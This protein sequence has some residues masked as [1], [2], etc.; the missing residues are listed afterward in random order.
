MIAHKSSCAFAIANCPREKILN[1]LQKLPCSLQFFFLQHGN[2]T[3]RPNR[4]IEQ[5]KNKICNLLEFH[6]LSIL[7]RPDQQQPTR[8]N[9]ILTILITQKKNERRGDGKSTKPPSGQQIK[10]S[11]KI[12]PNN[13]T[14]NESGPIALNPP[15]TFYAS[16]VRRGGRDAGLPSQGGGGGGGRRY[17][18]PFTGGEGGERGHRHVL[19]CGVLICS[20]KVEVVAF[21]EFYCFCLFF[22]FSPFLCLFPSFFSFLPFSLSPLT[23]LHIEHL[24]FIKKK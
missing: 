8:K 4:M 7:Y 12:N 16:C 9:R 5:T 1:R 6:S 20:N 22:F 13:E 19:A 11:P 3:I 17:G 10:S 14:H 24:F 21:C 2:D 15:Y 23:R 18:T